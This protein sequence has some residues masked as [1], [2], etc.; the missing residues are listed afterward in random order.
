MIRSCKLMIS[1]Y[2]SH[3]KSQNYYSQ[4]NTSKMSNVRVINCK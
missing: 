4:N 1:I 2:I 3:Y